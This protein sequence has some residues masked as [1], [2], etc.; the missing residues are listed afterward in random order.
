[1]IKLFGNLPS[2]LKR[3]FDTN[4]NLQGEKLKD[5]KSPIGLSDRYRRYIEGD[6]LDLLLK[7]LEMDPDKR[8]TA[9]QA[10]DHS[11]FAECRKKDSKYAQYR[12]REV[13]NS[14]DNDNESVD[15]VHWH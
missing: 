11:Y 14:I 5:V 8:I 10:L 4:R 2:S 13:R 15:D 12:T 9:R 6:A 7:M 1:M 3:L